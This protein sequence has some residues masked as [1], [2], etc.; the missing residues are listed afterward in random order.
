MQGMNLPIDHISA[1]GSANLWHSF[2][3]TIRVACHNLRTIYRSTL[4]Y[5]L[6]QKLSDF[7]SPPFNTLVAYQTHHLIA[8]WPIIIPYNALVAFTPLSQNETYPS[9]SSAF[10]V[11]FINIDGTLVLIT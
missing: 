2:R 8:F 7:S 11:C 5:K 3:G 6:T 4:V 10:C 1:C 9:T